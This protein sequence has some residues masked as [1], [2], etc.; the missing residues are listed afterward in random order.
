MI[1]HWV[2]VFAFVL[3]LAGTDRLRPARGQR[4]ARSRLGDRDPHGD[5]RWRSS[6]S[7]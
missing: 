3:A 1:G 2:C 5:R 4:P 6:C 7:I